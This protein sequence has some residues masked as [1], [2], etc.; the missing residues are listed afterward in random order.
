MQNI[1]NNISKVKKHNQTLLKLYLAMLLNLILKQIASQIGLRF[2]SPSINSESLSNSLEV[3]VQMSE[4]IRNKV[5]SSIGNRTSWDN[6]NSNYSHCLFDGDYLVTIASILAANIMQLYNTQR[7]QKETYCARS[8]QY[9]EA[10]GDLIISQL[11]R[12]LQRMVSGQVGFYIFPQYQ[13]TYGNLES[14]YVSPTG[15]LPSPMPDWNF[16]C[17]DGDRLLPHNAI[18]VSCSCCQQKY[19]PPA[20]SEPPMYKRRK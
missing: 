8:Q 17:A 20:T 4:D 16:I 13:Y 15:I 7:V 5:I 6:F 2:H 18:K 11:S 9:L 14:R 1:L 3:T 19:T 10:V 12:H